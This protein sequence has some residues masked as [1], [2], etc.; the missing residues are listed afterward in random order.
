[1]SPPSATVARRDPA[2]PHAARAPRVLVAVDDTPAGR[3]TLSSGLRQA[4]AQGAEATVLHVAPPRRWRVGRLGPVRAV[5][6]RLGDPLDAPVLRDARRIG[7]E[8]GLCPR[9]ELVA[10]DDVDAAILGAAR[11]LG[12][13]TIVVGA[14]RPDALSAPLGVCHAVLRHAPVPVVVVPA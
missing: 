13:A 14:H 8:L 6:V 3:R 1:M 4:A 12:A 7:F 11:R 9:L 10:A 2:S 5:P